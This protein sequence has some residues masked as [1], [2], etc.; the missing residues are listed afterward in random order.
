MLV[1]SCMIIARQRFDNYVSYFAGMPFP[2]VMYRVPDI[3]YES[4]DSDTNEVFTGILGMTRDEYC[5]SYFSIQ[6]DY[7]SIE[8]TRMTLDAEI[9]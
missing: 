6:G 8:L 9:Y 2:N 3:T 4:K 1:P 7:S 5:I